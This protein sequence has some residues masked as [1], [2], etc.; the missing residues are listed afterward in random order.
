[1]GKTESR[2]ASSNNQFEAAQLSG[3]LII[4]IIHQ[5]K[6]QQLVR[7]WS[8]VPINTNGLNLVVISKF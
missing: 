2:I 6:S 7:N 8:V 4:T 1:M 3:F 5:Q